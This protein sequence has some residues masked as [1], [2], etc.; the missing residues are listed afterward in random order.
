MKSN[1][2]TFDQT[3]FFS[4][5]QK[6]SKSNLINK[7]LLSQ[8][9]SK[10]QNSRNS[11]LLYSEILPNKERSK[12]VNAIMSSILKQ[13]KVNYHKAIK[14]INKQNENLE[15]N[16]NTIDNNNKININ[17]EDLINNE[18]N[19]SIDNNKNNLSFYNLNFSNE[20]NYDNEYYNNRNKSVTHRQGYYSYNNNVNKK[21]IHS[22]KN[23]LFLTRNLG[24]QK[25]IKKK[26]YIQMEILIIKQILQ[27]IHLQITQ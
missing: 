3:Q 16:N 1:L 22:M 6:I 9:N 7:S 12:S 26:S 15:K 20:Q 10:I 27:L 19:I 5:A 25:K 21:D 13:G 2:I 8:K 24:G 14:T 11:N 17:N 4:L 18:N 23:F